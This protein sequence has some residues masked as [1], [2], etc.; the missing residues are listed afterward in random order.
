MNK[1]TAIDLGLNEAYND[2]FSTQED[3]DNAQRS[4][5]TDLPTA[6]ISDFPNHPFKVRMD[7]SMVEL[8][9]SVK[10]YGVLVPSLVRPMPD[11]SYQMVSGHRRKRAAELAGLPTVPCIIRE[12]TDDEAIIVMVDSNLQREQILPSEK[13][14]AYKMKLDAMKQQ[15]MRTDLTSVPL[16]QKSGSKT[17]RQLL[18]EQV[19]E[20]QDQVRR[21]IRL[22]NLI[23]ELLDM[24]DNSVL[25]EAGKLQMALRPAV[26]LSYLPKAEQTA[27]LEVMEE[28]IRTPSHAQAIKMRTFSEQGKLNP[29]VILS[30]MQEEKPNQVEQFKIPRERIDKFFKPGTP[31]QKI[32]DTIVKALE[33]YRKRQRE[34]ER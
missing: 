20:S 18:G 29:D 6:E 8:A 7:Q 13:A 15:G 23:P 14:V 21:Y 10:Q 31:A 22:T 26:E 30:I 2:L 27:L 12:L 17:S 24:V 28:E 9:D 19:G 34:M 1:G 33:L 3:R 16:A 11:G 5:V 4:Y 25:K 32:E